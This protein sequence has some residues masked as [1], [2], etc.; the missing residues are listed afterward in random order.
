VPTQVRSHRAGQ[1]PLWETLM[2]M[3]GLDMTTADFKIPG[4]NS[5]AVMNHEIGLTDQQWKAI[6]PRGANLVSFLCRFQKFNR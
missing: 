4:E 1:R 6:L 5:R 2:A 3:M